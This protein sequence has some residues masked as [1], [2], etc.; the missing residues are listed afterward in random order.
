[1]EDKTII[2][3]DLGGTNIR[4]GKIYNDKVTDLYTRQISSTGIEQKV[5]DEIITSIKK[6]FNNSILGIGVGVPSVVDVEKGIVYDVQNIP[7][8]RKVYLKDILEK[9]FKVPV[10]INND[11]NC[12]VVG[13]KYFGA[14]KNYKDIVGLILGTGLGSGIYTNDKLYMGANCGAGEFG[15]ISYKD[16]NYEDYCPFH[17][18][19]S[20]FPVINSTC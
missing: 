11:A 4:V 15:M 7:A 20:S 12:F 6:I 8:F 19:Y 2:G 18:A 1:M 14:G 16:S 13:E 9:E 5:I 17:P 3:V 10:Y